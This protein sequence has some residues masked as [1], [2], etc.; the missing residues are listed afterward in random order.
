M[1]GDYEGKNNAYYQPPFAIAD[2]TLR[3]TFARIFD[4]QLSVQNLFNNN[5]FN[6]LPAPNLGVP[7]IADYSTDGKTVQQGSYP[8]FLIPAV[9]R[10]VR[11]QVRAHL[12][13]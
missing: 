3:K 8:T 13:P 7:V 10:T 11:L 4:V 5:S 9:T 6:Y 2:L 1:G 12:G